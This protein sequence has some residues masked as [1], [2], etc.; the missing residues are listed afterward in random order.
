MARTRSQCHSAADLNDGF[1]ARLGRTHRLALSSHTTPKQTVDHPQLTKE[2]G[3][4]QRWLLTINYFLILVSWSLNISDSTPLI[5]ITVRLR[6]CI[7]ECR[8]TVSHMNHSCTDSMLD[9]CSHKGCIIKLRHAYKLRSAHSGSHRPCQWSNQAT[10][11]G[12]AG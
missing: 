2:E 7:R 4:A 12:Q 6:V 1:C 3:G 8:S 11:H 5:S 9:S 10:G